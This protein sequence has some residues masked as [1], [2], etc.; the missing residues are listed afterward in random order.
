M[1]NKIKKEISIEDALARE[2][3]RTFEKAE[4][5]ERNATKSAPIGRP[6]K[7]KSEKAKPRP[8]Y[9]TDAEYDKIK[10]IAQ[11]YGMKPTRWV[12]M[13]VE[14]EMRREGVL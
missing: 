13:I 2:D 1:N 8:L 5:A 14:K 11:L 3:I 6:A 7:D 4:K 10:R 12:K 9:Y